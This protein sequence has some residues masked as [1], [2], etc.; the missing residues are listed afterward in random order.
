MLSISNLSKM[1]FKDVRQCGAFID[2]LYKLTLCEHRM[3]VARLDYRYVGVL[4]TGNIGRTF[5]L[6]DEDGEE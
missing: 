3:Y 5:E 4:E 2:V 6:E 1:K